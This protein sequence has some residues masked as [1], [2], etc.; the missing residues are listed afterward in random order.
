MHEGNPYIVNTWRWL[1]EKDW[2]NTETAAHRLI[3]FYFL[4]IVLLSH[5]MGWL[6]PASRAYLIVIAAAK[7]YS[8]Y[9][10]WGLKPNNYTIKDFFTFKDGRQ[11]PYRQSED[12]MTAYNLKAEL[13]RKAGQATRRRMIA[14]KSTNSTGL[15]WYQ[16]FGYAIF[17]I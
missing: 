15:A 14:A 2:A 1:M 12:S 8:G 9:D 3:G 5:F 4:G 17:P 13:Q 6:N 11:T 16:K 7:A 10:W